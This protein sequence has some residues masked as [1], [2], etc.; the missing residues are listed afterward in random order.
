MLLKKEIMEVA[1][2]ASEAAMKDLRKELK[3]KPTEAPGRNTDYKSKSSS[4]A[5]KKT[6]KQRV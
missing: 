2:K 6:A 4:G 3:L 1:T 5:G